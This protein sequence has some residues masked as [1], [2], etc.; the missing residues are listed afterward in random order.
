MPR[1]EYVVSISE[2]LD[3]KFQ[4]IWAGKD[5]AVQI[6]RAAKKAAAQEELDGFIKNSQTAHE[7]SM[8]AEAARL[9][10]EYGI[11]SED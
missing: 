1:V 8:R 5:I 2:A 9:E 10:T 4:V 11:N 3:A 7:E 6:K